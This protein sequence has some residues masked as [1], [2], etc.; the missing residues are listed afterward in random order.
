MAATG[1]GVRLQES[2]GMAAGR[3]DDNAKPA[4]RPSEPRTDGTALKCEHRQ[5]GTG[6]VRIARPPRTAA[7]CVTTPVVCEISVKQTMGQARENI[8]LESIGVQDLTARSTMSR[9]VLLGIK[10]PDRREKVR[11]L[12]GKMGEVLRDTSMRITV[13]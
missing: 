7:V 6:E 11:V 12:A 13:V 5:I 3:G 4:M 2:R 9:C 1:K 10:K 8:D